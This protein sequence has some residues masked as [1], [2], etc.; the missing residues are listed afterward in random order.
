MDEV[1]TIAAEDCSQCESDYWEGD[2]LGCDWSHLNSIW[3]GHGGHWTLSSKTWSRVVGVLA[4]DLYWEW[5]GGNSGGDF[6]TQSEDYTR[7]FN[8][9]HAVSWPEESPEGTLFMFD[10]HTQQWSE[11]EDPDA[12]PPTAPTR[13]IQVD[14]SGENPHIV[15]SYVMENYD[16]DA[17]KASTGGAIHPVGDSVFVAAA[18]DVGAPF[19]IFNEFTASGAPSWVM[20][21]QCDATEVGRTRP[22]YRAY[23]FEL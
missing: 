1:Y 18:Q 5:E 9:Q 6:T 12:T 19:P 21:V 23:A 4:G 8:N 2:L 16:G 17:V 20:D 11:T 14:W 22:G 15:A 7:R 3:V 13:G 10:N